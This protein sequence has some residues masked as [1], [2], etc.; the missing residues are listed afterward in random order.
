M[1]TALILLAAVALLAA[2]YPVGRWLEMRD[3]QPEARGDYQ[4]HYAYVPT[5]EVSGVTYR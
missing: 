2:A 4:Q 3:A 1:C 5:I